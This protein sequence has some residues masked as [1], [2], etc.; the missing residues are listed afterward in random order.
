[1]VPSEDSLTRGAEKR[2][3]AIQSLE[4][5]GSGFY[6]AMHDLEIR[7]AGEVLGESQSGNLH[8]VG[9]DL[10]TQMLNAAVRALRSGREPDLLQ[11]FAA[12]TEIN[13]HTPALLPADYVGDV[14]QRLSLYKKLASCND[15]DSLESVREELI[16]RFGRLPP[17]ARAL[18]ETHRL[19]LVAERLGVRKIDASS[20]SIGLQF[21]TDTPVDPARVIQLLQ[22]DKRL[23]LASP[24]RLRLTVATP[25]VERRLQELHGLLKELA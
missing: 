20:D 13:L 21:G 18:F 16:D 14:Q 4:E 9:F 3:E 17:A 2:L 22:R 11:P 19:R 25:Q 1:M 8:E 5:L 6:L 15:E 7:G 12:V 10:Y 23:K 24:D